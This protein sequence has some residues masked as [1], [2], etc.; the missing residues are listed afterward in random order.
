MLSRHNNPARLTIISPISREICQKEASGMVV[1]NLRRPP[2]KRL[3]PLYVSTSG[4]TLPAIP[5]QTVLTLR[6]MHDHLKHLHNVLVMLPTEL[7][8]HTFRTPEPKGIA[9]LRSLERTQQFFAT[10]SYITT[11]TSFYHFWFFVRLMTCTPPPSGFT[12]HCP[13]LTLVE[14]EGLAIS[15]TLS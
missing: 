12:A 4:S 8:S 6:H 7:D 14:Q 3:L 1:I 15:I 10:P 2:A 9:A 11:F 13:P 5:V